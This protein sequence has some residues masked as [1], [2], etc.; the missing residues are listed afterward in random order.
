MRENLKNDNK[1]EC[2]DFNEFTLYKNFANFL[3]MPIPSRISD[4]V[5]RENIQ[6][7]YIW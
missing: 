3:K 4:G 5:V 7:S 2:P 1:D 6:K